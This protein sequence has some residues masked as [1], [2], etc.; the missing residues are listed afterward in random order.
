VTQ[1][2]F[3]L[4][5]ALIGNYEELNELTLPQEPNV[6]TILFTD[7]E[8]LQSNTWEIHRVNPEFPGDPIRSQR[9]LKLRR[10]ELI[11]SKY[12]RSLYIDNTVRLK[13]PV[14]EILEIWLEGVEVAIPQHSFR[15]N[16]RDEFLEVAIAKLDSGERIEEQFETYKS[17]FPE[18][19][20]EP[21]F[22]AGMIAR[23]NSVELDIFENLWLNQV[24]RYSRR[25]QLSLNLA[26]KNSSVTYS[27]IPIDAHRSQFHEWPIVKNR[28]ESIRS[29]PHLDYKS[30][31]EEVESKAISFRSNIEQLSREI[32]ELND[33][34]SFKLTKPLRFLHS[35]V[36]KLIHFITG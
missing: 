29:A 22:W 20:D 36:R 8:S 35:N 17:L 26:I 4:Y 11:K 19:L 2:K 28:V 33:S 5:T 23:R 27:R 12:E 15:D 25:D 3:A 30:R 1:K 16:L 31:F 14:S 10:P 32:K 7:S 21:I 9:V 6:D 34:Y 18:L 13:V 24:L